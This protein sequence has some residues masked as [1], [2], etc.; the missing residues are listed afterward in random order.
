MSLVQKFV[1]L[2]TTV[3]AMT[4]RAA[5]WIIK[6]ITRVILVIWWVIKLPIKA[7]AALHRLWKRAEALP[8]TFVASFL[9]IALTAIV[10]FSRAK[11]HLSSNHWVDVFLLGTI[12]ANMLFFFSYEFYTDRN[13]AL[14]AKLKGVRWEWH[15]RLLSHL[16]LLGMSYSLELST[17]WFLGALFLFYAC[18]LAWDLRVFKWQG[19][20]AALAGAWNDPCEIIVCDVAGLATT[21]LFICVASAAI[22]S[23][24]ES[25]FG[26][27]PR[28]VMAFRN[29]TDPA[30]VHYL[31]GMCFAVYLIIM[32]VSLKA[33]QKAASKSGSSPI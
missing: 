17:S 12:L 9:M 21:V 10:S 11:P 22:M 20:S 2:L 13:P 25:V 14:I 6:I 26:L 29:F 19:V 31:L 23:R 7:I 8:P 33:S 32:A 24:G 1:G 28:V 18:I 30:A 5:A 4:L 16:L 15:L 3:I 27:P